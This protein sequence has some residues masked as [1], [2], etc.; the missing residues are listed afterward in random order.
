[1]S[2]G[3]VQAEDPNDP[4]VIL[5]DLPEQE[6]EEFL[7]QYRPAVDGA[8]DRA[9]YRRLRQFLHAWR[10]AVIATG[11]AGYYEELEAVRIGT[12]CT[13]PADIRPSF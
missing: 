8:H 12:A 1:M 13:R 4:E 2:A 5:R 3:P 6:R 9:G 7:R 11:E 10:L